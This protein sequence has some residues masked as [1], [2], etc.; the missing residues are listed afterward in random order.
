MI[1]IE[2][3]RELAFKKVYPKH[4]ADIE[5]YKNGGFDSGLESIAARH[6]YAY[7]KEGWQAAVLVE[8]EAC[9]KACSTVEVGFIAAE[10]WEYE[11]A[12]RSRNQVKET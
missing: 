4:A 11:K 2:Q 6:A 9:A 10:A 3:L 7:F 12:I 8:R 5:I 1:E